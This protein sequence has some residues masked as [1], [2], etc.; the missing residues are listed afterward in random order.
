VVVRLADDRTRQAAVI[1]SACDAAR[2]EQVLNLHTTGTRTYLAEGVVVHS[3]AFAR[4]LRS[5]FHRA[6]LDR[7]RLGQRR[8]WS[9]TP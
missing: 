5:L 2:A 4:R 8:V 6:V 7:A 9:A 3:L 1:A